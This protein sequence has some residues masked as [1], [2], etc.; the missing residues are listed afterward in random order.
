MAPTYLS[1]QRLTAVRR[2]RPVRVGDV[3]VV[4]DPREPRRWLLKRCV[5]K[6][7]RWLDLRGDNA[8]GSTDS[9]V[10]GTVHSRGVRWIVPRRQ[11][12]KDK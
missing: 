10:F 2:W 8:G 1:G 6:A 12:T 7:G 11:S 3:V 9:R 5:T 4:Q